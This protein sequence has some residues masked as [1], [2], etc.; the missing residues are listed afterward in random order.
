M[1]LLVCVAPTLLALCTEHFTVLNWTILGIVQGAYIIFNKLWCCCSCSTITFLP[2][3]ELVCLVK[4]DK[5]VGG[6]STSQVISAVGLAAGS[7]SLTRSPSTTTNNYSR[8]NGLANNRCQRQH[9]ENN[10]GLAEER[11]AKKE[12]S[13]GESQE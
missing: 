11:I 9:Q 2:P 5:I 8:S 4:F 6:I 13:V 7:T 3:S 12:G 10:H 1:C